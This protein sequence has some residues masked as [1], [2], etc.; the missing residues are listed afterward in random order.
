MCQDDWVNPHPCNQ[1]PENLENIWSLYNCMWLTMGA[2][3]TQ[4]CDI[5]P[6]YEFSRKNMAHLHYAKNFVRPPRD[7]RALMF[8]DNLYNNIQI[9]C[10]QLKA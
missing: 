10:I 8:M 2:I 9:P 5:L 3:M 6:R 4:G 1:N 7:L